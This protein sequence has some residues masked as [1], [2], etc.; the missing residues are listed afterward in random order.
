M[1]DFRSKCEEINLEK[2]TE[3]HNFLDRPIPVILLSNSP[4]LKVFEGVRGNFFLKKVSLSVFPERI[5]I[6][7]KMPFVLFRFA[8]RYGIIEPSNEGG[9][10]P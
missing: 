6:Q 8:T 2:E 4:L 9:N 7:H 10:T 3:A 5:R 1:E